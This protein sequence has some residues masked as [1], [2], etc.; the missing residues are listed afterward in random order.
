MY[1]STSGPDC[2]GTETS[3]YIH[4]Y[5]TALG[6]VDQCISTSVPDCPGKRPAQC[7]TSGHQTNLQPPLS[8]CAL[9]SGHGSVRGPVVR[10]AVR[11]FRLAAVQGVPEALFN[12]GVCQGTGEGAPRDLDHALRL[13]TR[14]AAKAG[15]GAAAGVGQRRGS[16]PPRVHGAMSVNS[17]RV[18]SAPRAAAPKATAP[19]Y[20]KAHLATSRHRRSGKRLPAKDCRHDGLLQQSRLLQQKGSKEPRAVRERSS[21]QCFPRWSLQI[22]KGSSIPRQ[23]PLRER[24]REKVRVQSRIHS[25]LE[26]PRPRPPRRAPLSARAAAESL[27]ARAAAPGWV[28]EGTTGNCELEQGVAWSSPRGPHSLAPICTLTQLCPKRAAASGPTS[29]CA[30]RSKASR[31]TLSTAPEPFE[32]NRTRA[33]RGPARPSPRPARG[34]PRQHPCRPT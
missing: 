15:V 14:A 18:R 33:L 5:P 13:Y 9:M 6:L 10:R 26:A 7:P 11:W 28:E 21:L 16:R 22:A 30:G 23:E 3:V 12:L 2:P 20:R 32:V 27:R 24:A 19:R 4:Q 1:L 17:S 8:N 31:R 29:R 34:G 25:S